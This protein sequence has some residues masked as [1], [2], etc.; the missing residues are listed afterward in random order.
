[1]HGIWILSSLLTIGLLALPAQ[2]AIFFSQS[3]A[4][5]AAPGKHPVDFTG[6]ILLN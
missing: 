1:M 2:E 6:R 5:A 3:T 4:V